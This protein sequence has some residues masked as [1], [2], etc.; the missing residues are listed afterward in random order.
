MNDCTEHGYESADIVNVVVEKTKLYRDNL[1]LK[2]TPI[3]LNAT[4]AY[5]LCSLLAAA[6]KNAI[7]V[8]DFGGAAGAPTSWHA[9]YWHPLAG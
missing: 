4:S 5:T 1:A 3:E 6:G 9:Q 2:R 7:N 8:L